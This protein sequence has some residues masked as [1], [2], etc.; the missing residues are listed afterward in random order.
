VRKEERQAILGQDVVRP[1]TPHDRRQ[2]VALDEDLASRPLRGNPLELRL[3]NFRPSTE[4][5]LASL[6]GPLPYMARL[7]EIDAQTAVHVVALEAAWHALAVEEPDPQRFA[8]RWRE[9]VGGRSFD[10]VND[11]I[12]RHN[13]WYPAESRLPMD[14]TTGDHALVNGESYRRR[15]LDARWALE[16]LP[17]DVAVAAAGATR[18]KGRSGEA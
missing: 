8:E 10:E 17:A 1:E 16:R 7:R 9:T 18:V 11:L 3:R 13:A 5:Y 4:G 2:R 15:F 14:P 12:E 6:G